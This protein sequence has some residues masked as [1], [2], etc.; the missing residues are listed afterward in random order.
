MSEFGKG[1]VYN[2]I[3][4]AKHW[5]TLEGDIASYSKVGLDAKRAVALWFYGASD[6]IQGFTSPE[7]LNSGLLEDT[8]A[9][10]EHVWS[11]RMEHEVTEKE[12]DAVFEDL[13]RIARAIDETLGVTAEEAEYR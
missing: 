3:L 13:E 1:F 8:K 10:A 6:H 5:G 11:H 9:W 2:M 7:N 4:F 12:F